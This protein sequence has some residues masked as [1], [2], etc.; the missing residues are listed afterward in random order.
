[1]L[2][3]FPFEIEMYQKEGINV[4]YCGHP[5]IKQLPEKA[6]REQFFAK[7]GLDTTRPLVS[8]FRV[9]EPLNFAFWLILL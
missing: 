9:Q 7:H 3:I 8:I 1:M 6:D 4:H 5:L 2:C